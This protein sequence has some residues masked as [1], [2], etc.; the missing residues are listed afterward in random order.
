M[1]QHE[2]SSDIISQIMAGYLVNNCKG[3][4]FYGIKEYEIAQYCDS[5]PIN[6]CWLRM[7]MIFRNWEEGEAE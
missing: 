1:K 5:K 4:P 6:C 2:K 7:K 3:C